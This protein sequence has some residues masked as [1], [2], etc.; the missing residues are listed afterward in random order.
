[1]FS[2]NLHVRWPVRNI[3]AVTLWIAMIGA[4]VVTAVY[5]AS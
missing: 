1:M 4:T 5:Y 3:V 2:N